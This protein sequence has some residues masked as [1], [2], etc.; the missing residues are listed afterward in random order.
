[1]SRFVAMNIISDD[2]ISCNVLMFF[3]IFFVDIHGEKGGMHYIAMRLVDRFVKSEKD[4]LEAVKA[5]RQMLSDSY[6][7]EQPICH[8]AEGAIQRIEK[9]DLPVPK[10]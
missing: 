7:G 10:V 9:R 6:N 5:I 4:R 8:A 3:N 2:S 1:M